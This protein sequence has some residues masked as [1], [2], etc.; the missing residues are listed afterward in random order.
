[1]GNDSRLTPLR[2]NPAL[3]RWVTTTTR[4]GENKGAIVVWMSPSV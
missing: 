3:I 1:M 4:P 2:N